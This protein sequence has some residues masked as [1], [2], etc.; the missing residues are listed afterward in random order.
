MVEKIGWRVLF[1]KFIYFAIL[2]KNV[3]VLSCGHYIENNESLKLTRLISFSIV[4][5][6][7]ISAL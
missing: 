7:L 5:S 1:I 3:Y 2:F 6:P 4:P